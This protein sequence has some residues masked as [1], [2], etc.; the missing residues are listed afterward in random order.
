MTRISSNPNCPCKD[1][2][3]EFNPVNH[4]KGC[5]FCVEESVKDREIPKCFFEAVADDVDAIE[6]WSFESFAKMVLN[7]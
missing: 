1:Y 6:D 3:C 4:D 5:I 2:E 7:L